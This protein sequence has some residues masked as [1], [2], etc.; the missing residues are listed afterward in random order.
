M[1]RIISSLFVILL[2]F[3]IL[4]CSRKSAV[5]EN[6]RSSMPISGGVAADK[7]LSQQTKTDSS[8]VPPGETSG[9][10]VK[11]MQSVLKII[12]NAIVA[13]SVEAPEKTMDEISIEVEKQ[14]GYISSS[15]KT[16]Y[17]NRISATMVIKIPAN[18]L[19]PFLKYLRSLGK[20][21]SVEVTS[22]EVTKEYNDTKSWLESDILLKKHLESFLPRAQKIPDLL[23]IQ[24]NIDEVQRRIE[25]YK[26]QIALWDHLIDL[27]TV[28]IEIKQNEIAQTVETKPEWN[29]LSWKQLGSEMKKSWINF[30]RVIGNIIEFL[31]INLPT[32]LVLLLIGFIVLWIVRKNL[33][34]GKKSS[35]KK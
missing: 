26:G 5:N 29:L 11:P 6:V 19:N 16:T 33:H 12:K 24:R 25:Q 20:I 8:Y 18:E 15:K 1:K 27:S 17:L 35:P 9:S 3:S 13:I 21:E 2:V 31:L 34:I 10:T 4:S 14:K 22:D 7:D 32:I 28:S 23:E 30:A